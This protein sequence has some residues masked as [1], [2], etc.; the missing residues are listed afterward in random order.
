MCI[1][2]LIHKRIIQN[3]FHRPGKDEEY[4]RFIKIKWGLPEGSPLKCLN[5]CL[6]HV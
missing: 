4:L 5:S 3:Y 1:I 2:L 6:A